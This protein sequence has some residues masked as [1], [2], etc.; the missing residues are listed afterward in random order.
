MGLGE[1]SGGGGGGGNLEA[2]INFVDGYF[3]SSYIQFTFFHS[4]SFSHLYPNHCVN[5]VFTHIQL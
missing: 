3:A 1:D 4:S 5:S 2:E